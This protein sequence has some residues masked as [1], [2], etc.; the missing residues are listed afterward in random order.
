MASTESRMLR[1][2]GFEEKESGVGGSL[3]VVPI[4]RFWEGGEVGRSVRMCEDGWEGFGK[5]YYDELLV[6]MGLEIE[7]R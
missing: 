2:W 6:V 7:G 5:T 3:E 1:K 4:D